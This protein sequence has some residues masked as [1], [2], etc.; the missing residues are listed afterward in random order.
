MRSTSSESSTLRG[1][2]QSGSSLQSTSRSSVRSSDKSPSRS[3]TVSSYTSDDH[4]SKHSSA[5]D[6]GHTGS[7]NSRSGSTDGRSCSVNERLGS[8]NEKLQLVN[9][10]KL[11][12][13]CSPRGESSEYDLQ[14]AGPQKLVGV[15]LQ[16]DEKSKLNDPW[17]NPKM[18]VG[19]NSLS[20]N[21]QTEETS[22][23]GNGE[24]ADSTKKVD[25]VRRRKLRGRHQRLEK[26]D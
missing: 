12:K 25:I 5:Y 3:S 26:G 4:E 22:D 21:H 11:D 2:G 19:L 6:D 9:G 24:S 10:M 7:D 14:T 18:S 16:S 8:E 23:D 17:L 13:L 15:R 1:R 20:L